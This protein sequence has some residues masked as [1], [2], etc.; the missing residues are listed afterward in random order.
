[1]SALRSY[2]LRRLDFD[3]NL[4]VDILP[5]IKSEAS[6]LKEARNAAKLSGFRQ[7]TAGVYDDATGRFLPIATFESLDGVRVRKVA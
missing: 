3:G 4:T 1:M 2:A 5:T 7:A 6:I